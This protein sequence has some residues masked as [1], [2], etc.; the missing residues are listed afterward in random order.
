MNSQNSILKASSAC[1]QVADQISR[2]KSLLKMPS[3]SKNSSIKSVHDFRTSSTA[4]ASTALNTQSNRCI[5]RV[6]NYN[7]RNIYLL[8]LTSKIVIKHVS[9]RNKNRKNN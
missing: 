8:F 2:L 1:A 4:I 7:N 5:C 3:N 6:K 9:A